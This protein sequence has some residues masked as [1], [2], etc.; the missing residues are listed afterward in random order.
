[1]HFLTFRLQDS[2]TTVPFTKGLVIMVGLY[3]KK[4]RKEGYRDCH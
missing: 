2:R 4:E 3:G 1:M